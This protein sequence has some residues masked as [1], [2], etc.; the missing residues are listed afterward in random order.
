MA[1]RFGIASPR[2]A[3]AAIGAVVVLVAAYY[4]SEW[5]SVAAFVGAMDFGEPLFHDFAWNYYPMG[6]YVYALGV[7]VPGYFYPAFFALIL[8]PL[9]LLTLSQATVVWG[10]LQVVLGAL[11][12]LLC[13]WKLLDISHRG[14]VLFV[15]LFVTS[16]PLLN[17]FKWGQTSVLITLCVLGS[18]WLYGGG[19]RTLS[20]VL[21]AFAVSI[22]YY[23]V[24]FVAF[25]LMKRDLRFL[26]TFVVA[27][28]VF[29]CVLP[30]L[31]L[32]PAVWLEFE[33]AAGSAIADVGWAASGPNSQYWGHVILR[34]ANSGTPAAGARA[35][36]VLLEWLGYLWFAVNLLLVW[37][38]R[39]R[40]ARDALLV[41]T[42]LLFLSLPF[43]VKT[44]WP[45]YFVYLPFCQAAVLTQIG[46][47]G[48]ARRDLW[49]SLLLT[50]AS[51]ALASMPV[52]NA[53]RDWSRYNGAGMLFW[54]NLAL[55]TAQYGVL[56]RD[57][58][59]RRRRRV[60]RDEEPA[61]RR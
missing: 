30:S 8:S 47:L 60:A 35:E 26:V 5:R 44:S 1:T 10:V 38:V 25:P 32:G 27:V 37:Q 53:F 41:S 11:L 48:R 57:G 4:W 15:L 36:L 17:N 23:G 45:H 28:A 31:A 40:E 56:A 13:G 6:R 58:R 49:P 21:L 16:Y 14:R 34:L 55:M 52:F 3:A 43:I 22:K 46:R 29:V 42:V 59:V 51:V 18:V 50:S 12:C 19:R 7:P 20:A 9:G 2:S 24:V 61:H 39:R 54:S 33:R